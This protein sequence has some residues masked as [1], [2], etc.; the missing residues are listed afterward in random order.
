M[1]SIYASSGYPHSIEMA[2]FDGMHEVGGTRAQPWLHQH[3]TSPAYQ[4]TSRLK[5]AVAL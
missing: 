3:L 1:Q 5:N 4:V 2:V